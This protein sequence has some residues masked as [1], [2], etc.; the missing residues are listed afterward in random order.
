MDMRWVTLAA[1]GLLFYT[2]T[3]YPAL[4]WLFAKLKR[5]EAAPA[6][7]PRPWPTVSV[8]VSAYNEE[9]VIGDRIRNL[10]S[11]DYPRDRLE[12][13]VGADGCTD[14][15]AEIVE[16]FSGE[17]VRLLRFERRR[18]KASVLNDL[19]A[20]AR[21]VIVIPTDANTF[22]HADAV[23]ELVKRLCAAGSYCTVVG[24]VDLHAPTES[25]NLDGVYWRYETGIKTLESRF[26]SVL[27]ANGP[28]Y[29]FFRDRYRPL[30]PEAIVDDFLVPMLMRLHWDDPIF[31][32][33]EARSWEKSPDRVRDEFRR[34]VRI[35]SGDF[36]ALKWT[37]PLLLPWKGMIAVSYFSHKVLRW[38]GPWLMLT[39]L[40]GNLFLLA[41]PLFK[42]LFAAQL[43][44]Y[45][46]GLGA[47]LVRRVP[48]LGT[49]A[50]AVHYF[51]ILNAGLFLGFA[52]LTAG[53][54][55][56]T[57]ATTP[58]KV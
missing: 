33:S 31:F 42:I 53:L 25:G 47:A 37:W 35:G 23:R 57:W 52:R 50:S 43:S 26:G 44:F 58:R 28:I 45:T 51:L 17:G 8:V 7:M 38:L 54:A 10:L 55:R 19:V 46:L 30:A 39:G 27:G 24:R 2:Y 11:L 15:T 20:A 56:P 3:G 12:I 41:N 29:A 13:L 5:R 34:R 9:T 14:R 22:F 48:V 6:A 16:S 21:G 49:L 40:A 4:L 18:G 1:F 36:Q 32:S